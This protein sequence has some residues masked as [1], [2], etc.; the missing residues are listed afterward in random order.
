TPSEILKA[1]SQGHERLPREALE[2]ASSQRSEVSVLLLEKLS[3]AVAEIEKLEAAGFPRASLKRFL[4][5]PSPLFFGVFLLADWREKA[6]YRP[7]A[8]VMRFPWVS[9]DK[10]LGEPALEEPGYRIMVAVF[11]GDPKFIFDIILDLDA[12]SSVRFWQWHALTLLALEGKLDRAVVADFARK[13]FVEM[14]R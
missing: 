1:L 6:A 12:N 7:L 10:M 8:R 5:A 14:A 4:K 2:A 9:H 3:Q 13:A 11:D